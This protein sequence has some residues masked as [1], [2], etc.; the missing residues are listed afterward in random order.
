ML[1]GTPVVW[2]LDARGL[3]DRFWAGCGVQVVRRGVGTLGATGAGTYLLLEPDELVLFDLPRAVERLLRRQLNT[4][5]IRV[6]ETER[7]V[8]TELVIADESRKLVAL[9][10]V[11]ASPMRSQRQILVT[12]NPDLASIW[13]RAATKRAALRE[14]RLV[15]GLNLYRRVSCRGR[16]FDASSPASARRCLLAL[17]Q[18]WQDVE[19]SCRD[20]SALQPGVRVHDTAI[21]EPDVRFIGPVW[22]GS[23]VRIRAGQVV[24]GPQI[25][26]DEA[27]I[28][29][30][31]A[32]VAQRSRRVSAGVGSPTGTRHRCVWRRVFDIAFS[33]AA[34]ALTAPLFPLIMLAIWLEDGRPLFFNHTRQTLGG[35]DFICFK[36]RTMCRN[37]EQ[38]KAQLVRRNVCDGPQFHIEDDPR[39]LRVGRFLRRFHLDELPQ[40]V[41]VLLGHMSVIGPRPSPDDENQFC[42]AW[43]DARLS[44]RPGLTGLWQV[45]RT[46][47]P[48]SDFQEWIRH[49]LDYV[50]SQSWR[51][52]L[53]IIFKTPGRIIG[54]VHRGRASTRRPADHRR[55]HRR[56]R[57][58]AVP[59]PLPG[60]QA[61]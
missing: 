54:R 27:P 35:Q 16:F 32:P 11:Y 38:L 58:G 36:F 47:A 48:H 20:V 33:V 7:N 8:Y 3:H 21:I 9:R 24:V 5:S 14:V 44:V 57:N 56:N 53:L 34:L 15:A 40:F 49:D 18:Q 42:P 23:G 30:A 29:P 46:R 13:H 45:S 41:N 52:D 60:R 12:S 1:D 37:A 55:T 43:R 50:E 22:V 26:R 31:R 61:S 10:R 51:L 6:V 19:A 25:V 2:G 28:E 17:M 4:V 59:A 39:L